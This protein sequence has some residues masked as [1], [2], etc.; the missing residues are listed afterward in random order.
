M[1]SD[2]LPVSGSAIAHVREH[3]IPWYRAHRRPLPWRDNPD[4]WWIWVSEVMA[5]QTRMETVVPYFH[6]FIERFPTLSSLADAD[7]QDVLTLWQGLGYYSRARNL[8]AGARYVKERFGGTL[9]PTADELV[10]I[11]GIGPYTAGAIASTAF[12]QRAPLVDGN[13]MRVLARLFHITD[14]IR[15]TRTQKHFWGI[16]RMLVQTEHP[17]D[18][19]QGLMELGATVCTPA[20]PTCL[21]CPLADICQARQRGT[22]ATVP[23]KSKAKKQREETWLALRIERPDG[24]LLLCQRP[25]TGLW[26]GLWEWPMIALPEESSPVDMLNRLSLPAG[27]DADRTP[28]RHV[29][30]HIIMTVHPAA[31]IVA[32]DGALQRIEELVDGMKTTYAQWRWW[33]PEEPPPPSSVLSDK[34]AAAAS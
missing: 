22:T 8:H 30:S 10:T 2:A 20:N 31:L 17:G 23:F 25:E 29:L 1:T 5:Q 33:S 24:S 14:D 34:L 18:L 12:G 6:R 3:L 28:V 13:V 27:V 15:S 32:D 11:P 4:P 26:S 7:T 19:N 16:A 9:P 21:L